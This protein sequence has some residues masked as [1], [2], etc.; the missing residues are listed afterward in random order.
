M[1]LRSTKRSKS[2]VT[3]DETISHVIDKDVSESTFTNITSSNTIT[4]QMIN[5]PLTNINTRLRLKNPLY[6]ETKRICKNTLDDTSIKTYNLIRPLYKNRS[7]DQFDQDLKIQSISKL[8]NYSITLD[9]LI[10]M[11]D[12]L[13]YKGL[14]SAQYLGPKDFE[15][16]RLPGDIVL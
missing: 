6:S 1:Q 7:N 14:K 13:Y 15:R 10:D 5:I 2:V 12:K 4:A 8:N 16:L 9:K 3:E 11:Q